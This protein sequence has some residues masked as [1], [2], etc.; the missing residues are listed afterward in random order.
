MLK[1]KVHLSPFLVLIAFFVTPLAGAADKHPLTELFEQSFDSEVY[2]QRFCGRNIM[3][4]VD[5]AEAR[6]LDLRGAAIIRIENAGVSNFG[7][8]KAFLAREG[9]AVI[10]EPRENGKPYRHYHAGETNWYMHVILD[11]RGIIYDFDF[12]N[13]PRVLKKSDYFRAMFLPETAAARKK[14]A[15]RIGQ[16]YSVTVLPVSQYL[17]A[18]K[19][20]RNPPAPSGKM[21]LLEYLRMR[22][23]PA[24][25]PLVLE[26]LAEARH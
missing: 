26:E 18:K 2:E 20:R 10:R 23:L 17:A 7:M 11:Y 12:T 4:F 13:E 8:V 3:R 25:S 22:Q 9:G 1:L 19:E 16:D 21:T 14:H 6:G 5:L 24:A 15:A